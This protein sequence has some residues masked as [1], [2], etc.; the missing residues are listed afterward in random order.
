[1]NSQLNGPRNQ[2]E[3][4]TIY[5]YWAIPLTESAQAEMG[6]PPGADLHDYR[7]FFGYGAENEDRIESGL[8]PIWVGVCTGEWFGG[9]SEIAR[10]LKIG[11]LKGLDAEHRPVPE[12]EWFEPVCLDDF[13]PIPQNY[14]K[15]M[16]PRPKYLSLD[17]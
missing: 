7:Y 2:H 12:P 10:Q 15:E 3:R 8:P 17:L 6:F 13:I 11:M 4:P 1:M 16:P 14:I 9:D 5:G